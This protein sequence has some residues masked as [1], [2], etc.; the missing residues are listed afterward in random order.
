MIFFD[1][2]IYV[3]VPKTSGSSF[4]KMCEDRHG[5]FK[6]YD[7]HSSAAD[8]KS[9]DQFRVVFGFMRH[10]VLSEYSNWRYHKYSW[11]GNDEFNFS[12]WCRWRYNTPKEEQKAYAESLGLK[13][14]QIEYGWTFNVHPQAG[15]FCS[16][17][18]VSMA[19]RI[20]RFEYDTLPKSYAEISK[21]TGLNC[22]IDGYQ[23]MAYSW[24]R[25]KKNYWDDIKDSDIEI[26]R[27]AKAI[28]F[29]LWEETGDEI[30][31]NFNCPAFKK[32]TRSRP[33]G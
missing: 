21:I 4:E 27:S 5:L 17:N 12:T 7:I 24:G 9:E 31:T 23:S 15:Y 32:Y 11:R 14:K 18:G 29:H 2:A 13:P 1:N 16:E 3:H 10:P 8:I 22:S 25:G 20:F 6:T 19:S 33:N 30:R 26:L 28:D